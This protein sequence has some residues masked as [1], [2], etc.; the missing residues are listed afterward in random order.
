MN[1]APSGDRESPVRWLV[2]W[3]LF[4]FP[5]AC[6][7][8]RCIRFGFARGPRKHAV[9]LTQTDRTSTVV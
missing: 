9:D 7:V 1:R 3:L 2:V 5:L 6:M 8:G 4:A